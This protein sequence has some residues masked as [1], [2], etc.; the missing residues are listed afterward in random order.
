LEKGTVVSTWFEKEPKEKGSAL[1][2]QELKQAGIK[3][4]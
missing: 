4:K 1:R 2:N 3:R